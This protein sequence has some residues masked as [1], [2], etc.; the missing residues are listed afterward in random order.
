VS[1]RTN[2]RKEKLDMF[3]NKI[4]INNTR[5]FIVV[6][7]KRKYRSGKILQEYN[8][9]LLQQKQN[10]NNKKIYKILKYSPIMRALVRKKILHLRISS[11]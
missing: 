5:S 3:K 8:K 10:N 4:S 2:I 1:N 7:T 9:G 11:M 6:K